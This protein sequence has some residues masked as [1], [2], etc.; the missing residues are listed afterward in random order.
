MSDEVETPKTN[1]KDSAV[2]EMSMR[3]DK[4]SYNKSEDNPR[5]WTAID[6]DTDDDLYA[7][8]M[9]MELYQDFKSRIDSNTPIPEEFK[10]VICEKDWCGGMPYLSIAHYKAGGDKKNVPGDVEKVYIDGTRLKSKGTL[11]DNPLG[12][13]TFE[14]LVEDLYKRKSGDNEHLPVRISIGFL[15]LEHKHLSQFGGQEFTF[16]RKSVGEICPLC[17]TGISGKIYT[18]GQLVHLAMTRVP[19]NP[20]TEMSVEKSMDIQTKKDDAE[21]IV[22]DLANELEEKSIAGDMLVV[23]SDTPQ[24]DMYESC[25]ECFDPNTNKY[26]QAC[27]D[28]HFEKYVG[29]PRADATVKS[30]AFLDAVENSVTK[31]YKS[32]GTEKPVVEESMTTEVKVTAS[33]GDGTGSVESKSV[34]GIPEKPFSYG[35]V[36]GDGNNNIPNPVKAKDGEAIEGE[37]EKAKV[38]KE[39]EEDEMEKAFTALRSKVLSAKSKG[40]PSEDV[41]QE[42]NQAFAQLGQ[43]VEQEFTAKPANGGM[44]YSAIAEI[45]RSAVAPLQVELASLKAQIGKSNTVSSDGVVKSKA[46]TLS[47][48][49]RPEDMLQRSMPSQPQR[50]LSQIERM[51]LK[52]T[53]ALR[54]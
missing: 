48:Y 38:A 6:S 27:I 43:V 34:L 37:E 46:L 10:S 4:A 3:I 41:T 19:V 14:A 35:G 36:T 51:A 29:K 32:N 31:I 7:E 39:K 42:I 15:D 22:G 26:D 5:R 47:G 24:S 49:T 54:E 28:A 11:H 17:A 21:S 2:V 9:S 23:R 50:K 40:K 52:S 25:E 1:V 33:A 53:G 20:R 44:D 30:K 16:T 45:I 8:K 12:R 18:K 13:K